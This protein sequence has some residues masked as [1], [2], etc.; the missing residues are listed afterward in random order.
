M[1][2]V[3]EKGKGWYALKYDTLLKH[4]S[5]ILYSLTYAYILY[6]CT[7]LIKK[8]KKYFFHGGTDVACHERAFNQEVLND[9]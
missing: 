5:N 1:F 7:V 8:I 9:L 3:A 6:I 2:I 4:F